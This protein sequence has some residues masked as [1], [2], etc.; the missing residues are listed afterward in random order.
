M[1]LS[2]VVFILGL[3]VAVR[4]GALMAQDDRLATR[5]SPQ[6]AAQVQVVVDSAAAAG[7]PTEPLIDIALEGAAKG[8]TSDRILAA[9]RRMDDNLR[10]AQQQLGAGSDATELVT[11]AHALRQGLAPQRLASLRAARPEGSL[12]VL[13]A[14][15]LELVA[16]GVPTGSADRVIESLSSQ[17]SDA[18]FRAFLVEVDQAIGAGQDAE[19][20]AVSASQRVLRRTPP[21]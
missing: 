15:L 16:R 9:V 19:S 20:A 12:Q 13:L 21:P 6:L 5:L 7:L 14:T 10:V 2:R 17:A 8:A 18:D 1:T 11:G 3:A 4:A